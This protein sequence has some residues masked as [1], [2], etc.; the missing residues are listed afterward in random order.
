[1][2]KLT[3]LLA[4]LFILVLTLQGGAFAIKPVTEPWN[5]PENLDPDGSLYTVNGEDGYA[6]IWETPECNLDGKYLL[7]ENGTELV[8]DNCLKQK[9]SEPWGYGSVESEDGSFSGWILMSDLIPADSKDTVAPATPVAEQGD[10]TPEPPAEA[11]TSV[12]TY[13][14]AIVFTCIAVTAVA[15][16]LMIVVFVKNKAVNKKGE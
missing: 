13:N 8:I 10:I 15:V 14:R 3:V 7:V 11:L 6:V 9:D 4:L 16:T 12:C 5:E 1:M 2:K